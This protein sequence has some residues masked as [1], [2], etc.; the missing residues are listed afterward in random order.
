V[1][2]FTPDRDG[3]TEAPQTPRHECKCGASFAATEYG[4]FITHIQ[5]F[6]ALGEKVAKE[7]G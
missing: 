3:D 7:H 5:H 1:N 2:T 4:K 6:K